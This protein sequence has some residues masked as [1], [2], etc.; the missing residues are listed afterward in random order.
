MIVIAVCFMNRNKKLYQTAFAANKKDGGER[1]FVELLFHYL[2]YWKWFV[3]SVVVVLAVALVYIRRTEAVYSV[4]STVLLKHE[5]DGA[6]TWAGSMGSLGLS[7]MRGVSSMDNEIYVMRS[8]SMI[9]SVV[10]KLNLHTS[11]KLKKQLKVVDV[12]AQ[13]PFIVVMEGDGLDSL[14]QAVRFTAQLMEDN[15]ILVKGK[16]GGKNY[17]TVLANLPALLDTPQGVMSFALR[18]GV[19]PLYEPLQI[20]INTPRATVNSFR[21]GL[22]IEKVD[23]FSAVLKMAFKS[24]STKKGVDFLDTLIEMYNYRAIEDKNQE[25][26]STRNFIVDRLELVSRELSE[27]EGAVESYKIEQG[28]T[29]LDVDMLRNLQESSRYEQQLV[30]AET[31]LNI[32]SGLREWVRNPSNR[33]RALPTNIGLQDPTLAATINEYNKLLAERDRLAH[34]VEEGNPVMVKLNE[35]IVALRGNINMSIES[36]A[37]GLAIER[38]NIANQ[39]RLYGGRIGDLPKREREFVDVARSQRVKSELYTLLL[40]KREE[41][42]LAIAATRNNATVL[43]EA[44]EAGMVHPRKRIILLGAFLFALL[45]P[46]GVIYLME[47]LQYKIRS[48][49]DV[50]RLT[51]IPVLGELPAGSDIKE[52]GNIVVWEGATTEMD[53]AFRILRTNLQFSLSKK[54][55]VVVFTSTIAGEG[56]T[57]SAINM[58]I[59]LALLKKKVLLIEMDLRLPRLHEY[60]NIENDRGLTTY[61]LGYEDDIEGL[62]VDSDI[63]EYLWVLPSGAIPPN[64][65][66]LLA[67]H[68]LDEAMV[69]LRERF[70]YII[71]DSA[72]T[73]LV[74]DTLI[75]N[76]IADANV[77]M[78]RANYSSK[79][80]LKF[81]NDLMTSGKLKN[82]LLVV[83][84]VKDFNRGYGYGYGKMKRN[85]TI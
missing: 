36:V 59:G 78:C 50:D 27:V 77:Y 37:E 4:T 29:D 83:N 81:A 22:E 80:N 57:F 7:G 23:R 68:R 61:L 3:V 46:V 54:D 66:E 45:L 67:R 65:S 51:E 12:Y 32:V 38:R 58:S 33:E 70:D 42:A 35:Q 18:E 60:M 25:A 82:M 75:I 9:R 41:N 28:M 44:S 71:I 34:S 14:R 13:T 1:G 74:T 63:N 40:Q 79:T 31:Q 62:I 69:K 52:E 16:I 19:E 56:K 84:D 11:Y 6:N 17:D 49:A 47:L 55:K 72:P 73:S 21:G 64:P 2:S 5:K 39:V 20:T 48:R 43:D 24:T 10:D 53:E 76:R 26:I 8:I 15:T 85:R 30:K